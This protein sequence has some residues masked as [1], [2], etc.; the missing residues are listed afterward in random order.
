MGATHRSPAIRGTRAGHPAARA[1][2]P[3]RR[4]PPAWSRRR[5]AAYCGVVGLKPTFGRISRAGLLP[6]SWS[7]DH[8]G[9]IARSV[10]DVAYLLAAMAGHDPSDPSTLLD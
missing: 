7:L 5:P 10:E 1:A 4:W 3:R 8:P 9:A 2:G 6:V